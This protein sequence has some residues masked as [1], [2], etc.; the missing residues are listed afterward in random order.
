[1]AQ[2]KGILPRGEDKTVLYKNPMMCGY[3]IAVRIDPSM[4]RAAA[5]TWLARV[6]DEIDKLVARLPRKRGQEKGDKVA[7][8]AL[9]FAP[10]FFTLA[11]QPRFEPAVEPPA[12]FATDAPEPMP[13]AG[14]PLSSVAPVDGDVLFYVASVF[15]ARVNEF[16]S[17]L[18][19]MPE[20][21]SITF[22]RGYQRVD[23]REPF[24]Y[25]DG[26]RNIRKEDRP[27]FVF[28][29]RD[30]RNVEE[31]AWAEGGTYMAFLRIR[32][33]PDAFGGVAD[34]AARDNIIG[35]RKNGDRIDLEGQGIEPKD[36]PTTPAPSL[37]PSSH[38]LKVGPRG[39]HDDTQIFR[40]GLPFIE[41]SS[42]GQPHIGLNFCSFQASLDQFDVFFNDWA[43]N[44]RFPVDGA[45]PDAL[46]DQARQPRP[47]TTIEK[48]GFF[49]VPPYRE[50]G[51][52]AAVFP[53]P[54]KPRKPKQGRLI[55]R[56]RVRGQ[57]EEAQRFERAGFVF[58]VL[59]AQSQPV[60]GQ[61]ISD[62]TGRAV[63]PERLQIGQNY[64]LQEVASPFGSQVQLQAI[65]FTMQK[66]REQLLVR[67]LVS[68]TSPYG[69]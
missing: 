61:F 19:G 47:L 20:V 27:D 8:V 33:H 41:T 34:D 56:K 57:T 45:G 16:I 68:P 29:D 49:F 37:P 10:T 46:L 51:L 35:R 11:G 26:L 31:P 48:V 64:L 63:C 36:E 44:T 17:A 1:M 50:E 42:D 38:V 28:V 39:V 53:A 52:V 7:A 12:A 24:G 21:S 67:N 62:R 59:D 22:D 25:R 6:G 69:G 40:R 55:V 2:A 65:P 66:S 54:V 32:Q 58:Q 5:E 9:G 43:M 13:H 4:N 18:A 60:G 3:F 14:E 15:E 23:E 30:T